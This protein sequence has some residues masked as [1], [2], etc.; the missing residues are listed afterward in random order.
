MDKL[1]DVTY[2]RDIENTNDIDNKIYSD[3]ILT[4]KIHESLEDPISQSLYDISDKVSPYLHQAGIT[5][6]MVTTV[7]IAMTLAA[8]LHYFPNGQ[9]RTAALL[10]FGAYFGDCLDGHMARKYDQETTFGDLYDHLADIIHLIMPLYYVSVNVHTEYDWIVIILILLAI[11]SL[12]QIGCEERYLKLMGNG[13]D[14]NTISGVERL[15]PKVMV[16][17]DELDDLMQFSR[18]FGIGVFVLIVTILIWNFEYLKSID[19]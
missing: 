12:V 7:R 17:D 8:F 11:I 13:K 5:P 2:N 4:G 18:L 6:N 19:I 9:Y 16:D 10:Y 1:Y 15:C 3:T 14:S